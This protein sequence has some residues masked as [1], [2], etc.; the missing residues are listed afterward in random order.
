[1]F[2]GFSTAENISKSWDP[3]WEHTWSSG[4]PE[5]L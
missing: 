1:M 5:F 2:T 3:V 4:S